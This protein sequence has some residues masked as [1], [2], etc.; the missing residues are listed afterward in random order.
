MLEEEREEKPCGNV[1]ASEPQ[2]DNKMCWQVW[3]VCAG[4]GDWGVR[5]EK[6]G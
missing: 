6:D 2:Q 5:E 3:G 1:A 4:I